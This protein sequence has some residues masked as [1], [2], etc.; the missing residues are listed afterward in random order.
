MEK[1]IFLRTEYITLG[2]FLKIAGI[3]DSGGQAKWFLQ[4]NEIFVNG[5]L[6]TRRGRKLYAG[7]KVEVPDM[8]IFYM[9]SQN[10]RK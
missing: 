8:G 9:S 5:E 4:E 2:Q 6:E 10:Q 3:I 7:D 1:E